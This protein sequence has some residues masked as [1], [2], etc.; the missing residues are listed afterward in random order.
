MSLAEKMMAK[1]G[2]VQG[3]GLGKEGHGILNPIEVK[4]RPQGAGVGAVKE[5]TPQAKAEARRVA[6]QR[7]EEFED[8]SEEERNARKARRE[9]ARA[10]NTS[11]GSGRSTPRPK[12]K[13]RTV[14]EIEAE[15]GLEVPNVFKSLIDMTGNQ[16][17]LLTSSAGLLTPRQGTIVKAESEADKLAKYA[18]RELDA[19]DEVWRGLQE[20]RKYVDVQSQRLEHEISQ[21]HGVVTQ[22]RQM[23]E[24]VQS[25]STIDLQ[26]STSMFD[27]DSIQAS[28]N[29]VVEKLEL[30]QSQ[31]AKEIS[32][33][34]LSEIAVAA[35]NP[36]FKQFISIWEP[37]SDG[38]QFVEYLRR[39]APVLNINGETN[40]EP[41]DEYYAEI[42]HRRRVAGPYESM[43]YTTWLPK[44]RSTIVNTW[45]PFDP[46]AMLT[47]IAAWKD[48]L[49]Q[50]LYDVV[51][52]QLIAQR[53]SDALRSWKPSSNSRKGHVVPQP[54][55]WLFPWLEHL[56]DYHLNA[57]NH[58]SLLAEVRRK[59]RSAFDGWSPSKG[60]LPGLERWREVKALRSELDKDLELRLLPT[61]AR[62]LNNNLDIDPADQ[63][64]TPFEQVLKWAPM[65]KPAKFARI[66][67]E[68]FFPIWHNILHLWLTSS[69][70][71][72]EI[73]EWV[74]WWQSIFPADINAV[75]AIDDE[76]KKGLT[77]ISQAL[78]LGPDR[79]RSELQN[80]AGMATPVQAKVHRNVENHHQTI[81]Q[82]ET[83]TPPQEIKIELVFKDLV[84]EFCEL[85]NVLLL[86]LR[87]AHDATG[88]P[89]YRVTA[90]AAG[91]RGVTAYMKSD[92]LWIQSKT[93]STSWDAVDMFADGVL[94][95][96]AEGK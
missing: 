96:L 16:P 36:F 43:I 44:M 70:D 62:Y 64:I 23:S 56:D 39:L 59:F 65:F 88:L 10:G 52:N 33:Y 5:K 74:T 20:R 75:P 24:L 76:W 26:P 2:Y 57:R 73:S 89:L 19:F 83:Q 8:S 90:N 27:Y 77:T 86:P 15:D 53:L 61:L 11:G 40:T 48:V 87:K 49:P 63:D 6:Q 18:R 81:P 31:Y 94:L 95:A 84:E 85:A 82:K 54:H 66:F 69:Q 71:Y 1:M 29:P 93:D 55:V 51:V 30:L 42:V 91:A 3:Q 17:R 47:S 34:N 9:A 32:E 46:S 68:A 21:R 22:F 12:Q 80:P 79:S 58:T 7:G 38:D 41:E 92:V 67:L 50:S 37:L 14:A 13:V 25:L 60:I 72:V 28:I 45:D 4:L 78:K 35:L